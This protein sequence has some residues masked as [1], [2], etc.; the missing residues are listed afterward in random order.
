MSR[1]T[2]KKAPMWQ[3]VLVGAAVLGAAGG[4]AYACESEDDSPT[5]PKA[6]RSAPEWIE[7][8]RIEPNAAIDRQDR[9]RVPW[10]VEKV[11]SKGWRCDSVYGLVLVSD[12]GILRC[13]ESRFIYRF[14]K[15]GQ[16]FWRVSEY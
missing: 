15:D 9:G 12:E 13:N 1:K 2:K 14:E 7:G 4:L 11:K 3:Q 8:V 10:A 6:E 16:G 5:P